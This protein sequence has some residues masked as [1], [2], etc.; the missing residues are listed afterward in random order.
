MRPDLSDVRSTISTVHDVVQLL[1]WALGALGLGAALLSGVQFLPEPVRVDLAL[2]DP[3]EWLELES[4]LYQ[5]MAYVL[6]LIVVTSAL[7][8]FASWAT[9]AMTSFRLEAGIVS[10]SLFALVGLLVAQGL[11]ALAFG[12]GWQLQLPDLG[13]GWANLMGL[14]GWLREQSWSGPILVIVLAAFMLS[15]VGALSGNEA[16]QGWVGV[17]LL[18]PLLVAA[19]LTVGWPVLKLVANI[20]F[21]LAWVTALIYLGQYAAFRED[22]QPLLFLAVIVIWLAY[23]IIEHGGPLG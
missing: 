5:W 6:G 1:I 9:A 14:V 11:Y 13:Q 3:R 2:P 15:V 18:L 19:G 12:Q 4:P 17:I 20:P 23:W 7:F 10:A 16:A 22:S 8:G 21:Y